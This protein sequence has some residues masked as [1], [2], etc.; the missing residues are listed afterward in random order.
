MDRLTV[1][2]P[3]WTT[4]RSDGSIKRR[5][6]AIIRPLFTNTGIPGYFTLAQEIPP[7]LLDATVP[8]LDYVLEFR[9]KPAQRI[10]V[11]T[12]KVRIPTVDQVL[13]AV[14]FMSEELTNVIGGGAIRFMHQ[15]LRAYHCPFHGAEPWRQIIV[16]RAG[17]GYT[18]ETVCVTQPVHDTLCGYL[19]ASSPRFAF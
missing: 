6:D 7:E 15:P 11:R 4:M 18:V 16:R 1:K 3:G 14:G 8:E 5:E 19:S 10:E 13:W 12:G 2:I 9:L 17:G